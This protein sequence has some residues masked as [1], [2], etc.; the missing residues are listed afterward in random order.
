MAG[1]YGRRLGKITKNIP[2]P[3][4]KI[5]SKP[6]LETILQNLEE[7]DYK[8]IYIATHYLHEE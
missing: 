4:L 6:I 7:A 1:G 2:K 5:K 8:K 3:L